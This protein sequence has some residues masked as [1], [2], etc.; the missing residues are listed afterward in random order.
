MEEIYLPDTICSPQQGAKKVFAMPYASKQN[1]QKTRIIL[2]CYLFSF[3]IDGEK[4]VSY[5]S[6]TRVINSGQFMFLP[7]GNCLMSEKIAA[8]GSYKSTLL[9]V[10][11]QAL[12]DFFGKMPDNGL[13]HYIKPPEPLDV[14]PKAFI[15]DSYLTNY[16]S[17]L[18]MAATDT[19]ISDEM[20]NLK[21]E[22]L[23]IYLLRQ[24]ETL[25]PYF[26]ALT[27]E[28]DEDAYLRKLISIHMDN[29]ITVE[30]LAFLSNMSLSTFKRKFARIFGGA[31]KQWF[32][33]TRMQRAAD[34]LKTNGLKAS[35]IYEQLGYDNLSS[36]VQ[37]FKKIYGVTPKQYQ[38]NTMN[39]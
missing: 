8:N 38:L 18:Q 5:A 27:S 29:D 13:A 23:M 25:F 21:F 35:E 31:P 1:S 7:S 33:K 39:F 16:L 6:G 32:L 2:N 4:I 20:L 12:K 11:R 14:A 3:I 22:E 37:A 28:W 19:T 15:M 17:G 34:M 10:S 9:F 30:E 26:N 24:D 36:F